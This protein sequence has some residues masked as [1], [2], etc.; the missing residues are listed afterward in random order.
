MKNKLIV[1]MTFVG[2]VFSGGSIVAMENLSTASVVTEKPACE[3]KEQSDLNAG[4]PAGQELSAPAVKKCIKSI[5][6]QGGA[7]KKGKVKKTAFFSEESPVCHFIDREHA[8]LRPEQIES[9]LSKKELLRSGSSSESSPEDDEDSQTD[10][11]KTVTSLDIF[12][13]VLLKELN[14][15]ISHQ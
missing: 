6:K 9:K 14:S 11:Q 13:K 1:F 5:L 15:S 4:L 12:E 3:L 10:V 8:T 7:G 2:C